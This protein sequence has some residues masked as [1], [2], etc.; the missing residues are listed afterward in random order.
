MTTR[1]PRQLLTDAVEHGRQARR[2]AEGKTLTEYETDALLRSAIERKL[3]IVGEALFQLRQTH[4]GIAARIRVVRDV[5]AFRHI[6][7]HG[8]GIVE[9]ERVWDIVQR[10]LPA[11]EDELRALLASADPD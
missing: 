8:Y 10:F 3:M 5:V 4:P 6:L 11:L 7:V 9:N 1:S 2:F